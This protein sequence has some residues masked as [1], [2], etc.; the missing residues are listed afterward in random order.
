MT[1]I[2]L[3]TRGSAL[4]LAQVDL[5][6]R[7]GPNAPSGCRLVTDF[8]P[9][10]LIAAGSPA[11]WGYDNY[12]EDAVPAGREVSWPFAQTAQR[13]SFCAEPTTKDRVVHL[14]YHARVITTGTYIWESAIAESLTGTD[15]AAITAE[16]VVEIR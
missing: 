1:R 6:V 5:T 15:R 7:F 9:S 14:R 8:V 3:G 16:T 11:Q 10:G 13:V 4:A 12:P 2:V